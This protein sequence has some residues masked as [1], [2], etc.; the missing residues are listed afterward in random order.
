MIL[1]GDIGGTKI[2]LALFDYNNGQLTLKRDSGFKSENFPGLEAVLDEFFS[3]EIPAVDRACFGIAGPVENR[4]CRATNFPWVVEEEALKKY[5]GTQDVWLINDLSAMACATPFL[6]ESEVEVL[7]EGNPDP[8]GRVAVIA[9]GTGLGQ[10]FLIPESSGR[11]RALDS[12]GGHCDFPFMDGLESDLHLF[13]KRHYG[14]VSIERTL[15]GE[16]LRQIYRF[17]SQHFAFDEP[18]ELAVELQ[19]GDSAAVVARYGIE[20][21][22]EACKKT[23]DIFLSFY[24]RVAGNL[25]LQV[26]ARGGV[27]VGGGIA[28]KILPAIKNGLFMKSFLSKGRFSDFMV[29]VP[30]KVILDDRVSLSGA[31]HY[32]LGEK[33]S[34]QSVF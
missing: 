3:G 16:G 13:L 20:G 32:A 27:Y 10:A 8:A 23:L 34:R 4:Q 6:R 31:A 2:N 11:Y 5:L 21:K 33:I 24:G 29:K 17:V 19:R 25:A 28:P 22:S 7:Q 1:A 14:R 30:V 18:D 26:L 15:S 9:A 12:E